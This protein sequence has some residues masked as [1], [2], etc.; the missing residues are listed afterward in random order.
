MSLSPRKLKTLIRKVIK[1][2]NPA[3]LQQ[4]IVDVPEKSWEAIF[5]EATAVESF[6]TPYRGKRS[7]RGISGNDIGEVWPLCKTVTNTNNFYYAIYIYTFL[8][9]KAASTCSSARTLCAKFTSLDIKIDSFLGLF[10]L[11][12]FSNLQSLRLQT[13]QAAS[14]SLDGFGSSNSITTIS[15]GCDFTSGYGSTFNSR[16]RFHILES[17]WDV[18]SSL[19]SLLFTRCRLDNLSCLESAKN[20]SVLTIQDGPKNEISIPSI[21]SLKTLNVTGW[22]IGVRLDILKTETDLEELNLSACTIQVIYRSRNTSEDC[23]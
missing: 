16:A 11:E 10:S 12:H 3:N 21:R 15:F 13:L 2:K 6:G 18:P 1:E 20:L 23:N 4:A 22:D 19:E 5:S 9:S 14:I 7:H 17:K 8:L